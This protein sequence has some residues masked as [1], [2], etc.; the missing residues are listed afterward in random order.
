MASVPSLSQL[1]QSGNVQ[2][3][4]KLGEASGTRSDS[5]TNGYDLTDNNTV[6][7]ATG[8]FNFGNAAQFTAAN[9]EYLNN[10]DPTNLQILGDLTVSLCIYLDTLPSASNIYIIAEVGKS[11]GG[12]E[13]DN[14]SWLLYVDENGDITVGHEYGASGTNEFNTFTSANLTTGTWYHLVFRRDATGN[15][16]DLAINNV[17]ETQASYTNDATGGTAGDLLV[18][19]DISAPANVFNGRID[20]LI[21][22]NTRLTDAEVTTVNDLMNNRV[23]AA[24]PI[25]IM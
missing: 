13:T 7:Q 4:Y 21:V 5:S 1:P 19:S 2:G 23:S 15:T 14:R 11:S 25:I 16:F 10:V 17:S 12:P 22:W 8:R 24:A 9:N 20:E 18:G 3:F 6:T